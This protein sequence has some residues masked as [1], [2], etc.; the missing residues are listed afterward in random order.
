MGEVM[1][2]LIMAAIFII[3]ELVTLGL[4]SIWFAGGAFVAAI[5]AMLNANLAIQII[6]FVVVSVVLLLLTRP[7]ATKY[8]NSKTEKTN[9][10]AL[11][12]KVA[13]VTQEINNVKAEGQAIING[14]EW[15]ARAQNEKEIIRVGTHVKILS[16][17]G[18][19][20]IVEK[21]I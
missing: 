14:M 17:S 3:V 12:G 11:I 4:V 5:A 8:L 9:S 21:N 20:L 16:I 6:L 2:W 1:C 13:V 7:I 18:V 10:E 19:K 15:T